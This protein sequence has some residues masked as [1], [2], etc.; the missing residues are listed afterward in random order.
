M[1]DLGIRNR[2]NS[3]VS[4]AVPTE[5]AHGQISILGDGMRI[6]GSCRANATGGA[7]RCS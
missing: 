1:L 7:E 5:G 2:V 6:R 4:F 3:Y